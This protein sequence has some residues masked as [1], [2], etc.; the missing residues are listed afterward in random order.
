MQPVFM[1]GI[2]GAD[3]TSAWVDAVVLIVK[4]DVVGFAPGVTVFGENV[5]EVFVGKLPQVSRTA[6]AKEPPNGEIVRL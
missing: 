2:R 3:A 5:Q 1:G 4:V 6:L